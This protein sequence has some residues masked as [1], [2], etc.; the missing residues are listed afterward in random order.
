MDSLFELENDAIAACSC[1]FKGLQLCYLLPVPIHLSLVLIC[2]R[3][4]YEIAAGYCSHKI[5]PLLAL[6][7]NRLLVPAKLNSSQLHRHAG[8]KDLR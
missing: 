8:S 4:T 3:P 6:R 1:T 5:S 7:K 2:C